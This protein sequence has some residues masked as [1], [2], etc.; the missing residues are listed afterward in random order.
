VT[1]LVSTADFSHFKGTL[2]A[3]QRALRVAIH[4]ALLRSDQEQYLQIAGQVHD[5][6]DEA[7]ADLLVD[8]NLAEVTRELQE[9]RDIDAAL[10]RIVLGTYG[11]CVRCW[12]A[13]DRER[14]DAYPTAKCCVTC[15]RHEEHLPMSS[16]P[17]SL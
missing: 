12:Q 13:I 11:V 8:V 5:A 14:L 6:E 15:Q 4:E 9:L 10:R 7:L 3:R 17:R 1:P 2:Q 16:P